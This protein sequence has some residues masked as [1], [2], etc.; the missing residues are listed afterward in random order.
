MADPLDG[1]QPVAPPDPLA[2]AQPVPGGTIDPLMGWLR[3]RSSSNASVLDPTTNA[4][5]IKNKLHGAASS[6]G[7]WLSQNAT[8]W[9]INGLTHDQWNAM[10][11]SDKLKLTLKAASKAELDA[12]TTA[13]RVASSVAQGTVRTIGGIGG[14]AVNAG[15]QLG[16]MLPGGPSQQELAQMQRSGAVTNPADIANATEALAKH[17]T[18][19]NN[20][21]NPL[22]QPQTA[23]GKIEDPAAKLGLTL[24]G[25][26]GLA[27]AG[28]ATGGAGTR[29]L[30]GGGFGAQGFGEG[31]QAAQQAGY[32]SPIKQG[33]AVGA[34]NAAMGTLPTSEAGEG[35]LGHLLGKVGANQV[36]KTVGAKVGTTLGEAE[37]FTIVQNAI[38]KSV[39][40]TTGYFDQ[41]Q[42][43]SNLAQVGG[44]KLF[45]TLM[46]AQ[47]DARN[48]NQPLP[49]WMTG[50]QAPGQAAAM[51]KP[52]D[53]ETNFLNLRSQKMGDQALANVHVNQ[54]KGYSPE[55]NREVSL[56]LSDMEAGLTPPKLS[57]EG[58]K[59]LSDPA[60]Q[61][62]Q[63][64]LSDRFNEY[65]KLTGG[66]EESN[67]YY[68]PRVVTESPDT[69]PTVSGKGGPLSQTTSAL[70][71]RTVKAI[72]EPDGTRILVTP[73]G[74][75]GYVSMDSAKT[76]FEP[77]QNGSFGP[78]NG[79]LGE[80]SIREIEAQTPI[81]YRA[82]ATEDAIQGLV[83]MG[84]ANRNLDFLNTLKGSNLVAQP[85]AEVP[86]GYTS[87]TTQ[88]S[89]KFPGLAD[90]KMDPRVAAIFEEAAKQDAPK[91]PA[92]GAV[93]KA[94][95]AISNLSSGA[96]NLS[97]TGNPLAHTP[98]QLG[99]ALD[100]LTPM[101]WA[102]GVANGSLFRSLDAASAAS[103]SIQQGNPN[104]DAIRY[105]QAGGPMMTGKAISN[106]YSEGRA[107]VEPSINDKSR[108]ALGQSYDPLS[109]PGMT[110]LSQK[111]TWS[112]D[113]TTRMGLAFTKEAVNGMP[114]ADAIQEVNKTYPSYRNP[115]IRMDKAPALSQ[116]LHTLANW[117]GGLFMRY[118]MSAD[119]I[120]GSNILN[121]INPD[122]LGTGATRM[123]SALKLGQKVATGTALATVLG[124]LIQ[125]STQNERLDYM[126][127]GSA[128]IAHQAMQDTQEGP[129]GLLKFAAQ[130]VVPDPAINLYMTVQRGSF[131]GQQL[132]NPSDWKD[133]VL[134][135]QRGDT[136]A[137]LR[138]ATNYSWDMAKGIANSG[139]YSAGVAS[140]ALGGRKP[141]PDALARMFLR[142]ST[143]STD[144]EAIAAQA[145]AAHM[146]RV[147][148]NANQVDIRND[149]SAYATALKAGDMD[150][151]GDISQ[152]GN[153]SQA[154]MAKMNDKW[155]GGD[156][157]MQLRAKVATLP[158]P[159]A[160]RVLAYGTPEEKE[161]IAPVVGMKL[162]RAYA[163]I[164]TP[165]KGLQ[166][167]ESQ[168]QYAQSLN[169]YRLATAG[170]KSAQ[171][172]D[173]LDDAE[174]VAPSP[175]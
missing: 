53:V 82:N 72:Q 16:T 170:I 140:D 67:P 23:V 55:A 169:A 105:L 39:D 76:H 33:L 47:V 70:Q 104:P 160:V 138:H 40:P 5:M 62:L 81:R 77:N 144:A 89:N 30:L 98:N 87:L 86:E 150:A 128:H 172:P 27:A 130:Q 147:P 142:A 156:R 153:L 115:V 112:P 126:G 68:I 118:R 131:N 12:V 149:A 48:S 18:F 3:A 61:N 52:S 111:Y 49:Q 13:P 173:P 162:E 85:K 136:D 109:Q 133:T 56:Y 90:A 166:W 167:Q 25:A 141:V 17:L 24:L 51:Q 32:E 78:N 157:V 38:H 165:G 57:P 73:D 132:A 174:P 43:L 65:Q 114:L 50:R 92:V 83:G 100:S 143:N 94:F 66:S 164:N 26:K 74:N 175:K 127:G 93:D 80:A 151:L 168:A 84:T 41:G 122:I 148:P 71:Q 31:Y 7:N 158:Y 152:R 139:L 54:L 161:A 99:H 103:R 171:T 120:L 6:V 79:H 116:G 96:V 36:V 44:M 11:A 159:D 124:A 9:G 146:P 4:E 154:D 20:P 91:I 129:S 123:G 34:T 75:G 10:S 95:K 21:S 107:E 155:A 42:L 134:A 29:L 63:K 46:N 19:S 14:A 1:A 58:Q 28:G 137:A 8:P 135:I 113:D 45:G 69:T 125:Q 97:F 15:E 2:Q 102:K 121:T 35:V 117:P 163:K 60:F 37:A 145:A 88:A 119:G 108:M 22:S 59:L 64:G 101:E 110:P 106:A